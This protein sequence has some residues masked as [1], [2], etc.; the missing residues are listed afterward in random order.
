MKTS[1]H[2]VRS[3]L[4]KFILFLPVILFAETG[5]AQKQDSIMLNI[6]ADKLFCKTEMEDATDDGRGNEAFVQYHWA[7][8][9]ANN[10]AVTKSGIQA[11]L[12]IKMLF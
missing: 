9:N 8:V 5:I 11:N 1:K 3:L 4:L 12:D 10:G 7:I 2:P 6:W